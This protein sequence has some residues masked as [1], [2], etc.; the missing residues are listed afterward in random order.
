MS[1]NKPRP[2]IFRPMKVCLTNCRII[3]IP[4]FSSL[5]SCLLHLHPFFLSPSP[6]ALA[7]SDSNSDGD[8]NSSEKKKKKKSSGDA[9]TSG[10]KL[11][12]KDHAQ[13]SASAN[14]SL[15]C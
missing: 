14:H 4:L 6:P 10:E 2:V 11:I 1:E 8:L 15:S 9:A 12:T 5:S 7:E 3:C 13:L